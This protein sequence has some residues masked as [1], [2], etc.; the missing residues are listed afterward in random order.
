[1]SGDRCA[2]RYAGTEPLEIYPF[3]GSSLLAGAIDHQGAW[4]V[5]HGHAYRGS[6]KGV[7]PGGVRVRNVTRPVIKYAYYVY[8]L[9]GRADG[10]HLIEPQRGV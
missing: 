1:M 4:L 3:L 9:N 6:E 8:S 5:M 10:D 7:T 2:D